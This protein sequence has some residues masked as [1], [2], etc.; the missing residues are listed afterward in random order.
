MQQR[1]VITLSSDRPLLPTDYATFDP[2]TVCLGGNDAPGIGSTYLVLAGPMH[3]MSQHPSHRVHISNLVSHSTGCDEPCTAAGQP[4]VLQNVEPYRVQ[5]LGVG[6]HMYIDRDYVFHNL[7][8][9][10]HGLNSIVGSN[11]DASV[12]ASAD[13]SEWFCFDVN[14]NVRIFL[15]YDA[16]ILQNDP[17]AWVRENFHDEHEETARPDWQRWEPDGNGGETAS[18]R[19]FEVLSG[20]FPA[21]RVCLGGNGCTAELDAQHDCAMYVPFI[22]PSMEDRGGWVTFVP[23][24]AGASARYFV[25][26]PPASA[27][28]DIH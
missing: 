15:L 4:G 10:L 9:F 19:E 28:D 8:P 20:T 17:P 26:P 5:D 2:G 24:A 18:D 23:G 25:R 14:E 13:D 6:D 12:R 21:G 27:F 11:S 22:G 16:V 3:D 1:S 7:P